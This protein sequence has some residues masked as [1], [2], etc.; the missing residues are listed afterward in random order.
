M[1]VNFRASRTHGKGWKTATKDRKMDGAFNAT[2]PL[3]RRVNEAHQG[4]SWGPLVRGMCW[5]V[6][7]YF[8]RSL[9]PPIFSHL[10][11]SSSV[12]QMDEITVRSSEC[13]NVWDRNIMTLYGISLSIQKHCLNSC[14]VLKYSFDTSVW[15][16]SSGVHC[17]VS[18]RQLLRLRCLAGWVITLRLALQC[19]S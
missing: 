6:L 17:A 14:S 10:S 7:S 16:C 2:A 12:R 9:D 13:K 19:S 15:F 1:T 3:G 18:L 8:T 11:V 5:F 4:S